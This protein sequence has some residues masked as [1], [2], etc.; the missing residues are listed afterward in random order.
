[1]KYILYYQIFND[2][3]KSGT[4]NIYVIPSKYDLCKYNF[5]NVGM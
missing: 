1:M 3:I 5:V 2:V 4:N